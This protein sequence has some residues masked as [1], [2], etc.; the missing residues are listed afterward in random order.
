MVRELSNQLAVP[1]LWQQKAVTLLRAGHDVVVH[2]PTG[3][4]KTLIFERLIEQGF[5]GQ[6]VFTVPTRALAN[7][8]L[9]EWTA[10]GWN[11]GIETGDISYNIKA[12]VVVATLETR[13]RRLLR[14]EGPQLLVVDEYQMVGDPA[15]GVN[16][17]LALAT[18]PPD[19]QL[20]L[21][22]GSVANPDKV[23]AWLSRCGRNAVCV[24]HDARPVPLGEIHLDALPDRVPKTVRGR[25]PRLIARALDAALGPVLIFAP[26]RQA[27]EQLAARLSTEIAVTDPLILPREQQEAA[28]AQLAA[29]LRAR[30]AFHH[31]GMSYRQRA[32]VVEPL[33]K[34]NALSVIVA[35]T[36]LA[37]GINF[38]MRSVLVLDRD[39]RVAEHRRRL[40]PD[41]LLQM[42]GRAGRRGF[43][44]R[45]TA[46]VLDDT[47][48][49][50]DARA[51]PLKRG[52]AVD[53][54]SLLT[55][56]D[57]AVRRGESPVSAARRLTDRLFT[58]E[59]VP[60]GLE[61][62]LN[63]R[64]ASKSATAP[65]A[66]VAQAVAGGTVVEMLNSEGLWERRRAPL[67]FKLKDTL[68]FS[69]G[70]WWPGL[71][72]PN[73]VSSLR[74]GS[75]RK[76]GRGRERRYGLRVPLATFPKDTAEE[77]LQ[78]AK[79]LRKALR[80]RQKAAGRRPNV[81]RLW[82]L[83]A[84]EDEI[85]PTL[86]ELT[87][88]GHCQTLE[89]RGNTLHACLDY[90]EAEIRAFRDTSGM[91]LLNPPLRKRRIEGSTHRQGRHT[92]S[93]TPA[94]TAEQWFSLGLIDTKAHPTRRGIISSFF[95]HAE[96]LAVA[97]GLE[98]ENY[99]VEDLLYDIANLRAGHRFH[100][101]ATA[102]C[103]LAALCQQ[104]FGGATIGGYLRRGL[105]EDY[106]EG[107]AE[108]LRG[109]EKPGARLEHFLG[110]DL[111]RGDVERARLEWRSLRLH[112][113]SAPEYPWERWRALQTACR[114]SLDTHGAIPDP[115]PVTLHPVRNR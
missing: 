71:S 112:I 22:S 17:E 19:T 70:D 102:G 80:E 93:G 79:W 36:G 40:R 113:A 82:S 95:N 32:G 68:V 29:C 64:A 52:A 15:R 18:A 106:G 28:G 66:P 101:L 51:T 7:D 24:N 50:S 1:D 63:K 55:V 74:L 62:F 89:T 13:K 25:W 98:A 81:P 46:L 38:S 92:A 100:G 49:L 54:A 27:A 14:G 58:T 31:S 45:G 5:S 84:I 86:P 105:P 2:A 6:A 114:A 12:P 9:R 8:K 20:L 26:R 23:V 33:A 87:R 97:V 72:Q 104:A 76:T 115:H 103:P 61:D 10:K 34:A 96:G 90:D 53:W 109:L 107:A 42:F 111:S 78:L 16:Y 30:I 73:L 21:L 48:R 65:E 35:T 75:I 94:S 39:Y 91:G 3:A 85:V 67:L 108:V 37:A 11:V 47:P 60:L 59:R 77:R 43:D 44:A 110:E 83:E 99:G 4:G 88:G 41:E 56:M 69:D 57:A